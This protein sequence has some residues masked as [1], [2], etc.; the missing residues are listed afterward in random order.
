MASRLAGMCRKFA[1]V[2]FTSLVAPL[3]I[4]QFIQ[5]T[6]DHGPQSVRPEQAPSPQPELPRPNRTSAVIPPLSQTRQAPL[7]GWQTAPPA[8]PQPSEEIRVIASGRGRTPQ[9]ALQDALHA[10][11]RQAVSTQLDGGPHRGI[12]PALLE[13]VLRDGRGSIRDWKELTAR[14]EWGLKGL[15]YWEEVVIDVHLPSL[16]DRLRSRWAEGWGSWPPG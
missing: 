13:G 14:K 1:T 4:H 9:A 12:D 16:L 15:V 10:A 8:A 5:D 7:P 2:V 3:L 11:L 6:P